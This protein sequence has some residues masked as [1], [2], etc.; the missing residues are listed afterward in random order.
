MRDTRCITCGTTTTSG[1]PVM[2]VAMP[3]GQPVYAC[4]QHAAER[5][6]PAGDFLVA[7]AQLQDVWLRFHDWQR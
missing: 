5:E 6:A 7:L 2:L 1:A 4:P 3:G